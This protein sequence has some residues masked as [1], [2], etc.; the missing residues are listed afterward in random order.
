MAET[1]VLVAED[2]AKHFDVSRPLLQRLL[3][4]E[5]K[6]TLKAVDGVSFDIPK[7]T[8][9][10]LVGESGCGKS[11]VARLVVGLYRPTRGRVLF[12]G[13]E[14][15]TARANAETRR[16]MQMIFQDP[17]ASLN[18]RWRVRDIVAEPLRAFGLAEG[19]AA[20]RDRVG[21]LLTQ[22]GLSPLDGEKY[23][24]E[25]SGGQR[26]RIS[27]ARALSSNPDF[28]VCDEPTS[29]LDVSVQAQILNL[30]K[31]LQ[32]RLGLTYLFISHN[33]A[34][35]RQ[36]SDRIGVMYLGRLVELAPAETLF[37][38]PRHPYTRALMEAIPDLEMTGRKRI[39]VGGEV[40]SPID[41]PSGC[42]FHPRCPLA[43]ARCRAEMP[44]LRP[45][46][47]QPATMVA[48]H[49][50]EERRDPAPAPAGADQRIGTT[51]TAL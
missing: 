11:T 48:C 43:D 51:A 7:G 21:Q 24:H 3:A 46:E 23:P 44:A 1:P 39:P 41:P 15:E 26:Q 36:V 29:A 49:A 38:A 27:I 17:Y 40:P 14:L 9:L 50:V 4:G 10:S 45:P 20:L 31:D 12:E 30:M 34:V 2:L 5:G 35:V 47:A 37:T 16:R 28:L 42:P 19:A 32:Q 13:I 25:F 22:V 33:L 8:T 6:R 18:P